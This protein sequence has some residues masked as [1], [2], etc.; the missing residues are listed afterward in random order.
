MMSSNFL[1]RFATRI[2]DAPLMIMPEKLAIITQALEGRIGPSV[3]SDL[4]YVSPEGANLEELPFMQPSASRFVGEGIEMDERGKAQKLP[5]QRTAS[6]QAIITVSGSLMNRGAYIG[7]KSGVLSYEGISAQLKA[8]ASDPKVKSIVLDLDSPGGE[9]VGAME[10]AALVRKI[11]KEKHVYS[12]VNGLAASAGYA[13]ASGARAIIST[14]SGVSGSIGVVVQHMDMSRAADRAGVN[15]SFVHAGKHKVDGHSFAP[16]SN[17]VRADLQAEVDKYYDLFVSA[18]AEGRGRRMSAKSVRA[19]EA[20]TFIGQAAKEAGLVD[21][22]GSFD[23]LLD[24]LA[25][26]S[27]R[28]NRR[29]KH[30]TLLHDDNELERASAEAKAAGLAEGKK[31]GNEEGYARGIAEGRELGVAE[32]HEAGLAAGATAERARISA[33][34]TSEVAVGREASAN[35]LAFNSNMSVE[36]ATG[37]LASVPATT[38]IAARSASTVST[39]TV[40]TGEKTATMQTIDRQAIYNSVMGR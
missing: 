35:H 25:G 24:D 22:I 37:F 12:V 16:L 4:G 38:G 19:T 21:I 2:F 20:R 34:L 36:E 5:Y 15:V 32:G 11:N 14:E 31:A 17:D 8:A 7:A 1:A 6:G 29:S 26:S 33:I 27:A 9:A 39:H 23:L 10:T 13:L 40:D 18:V 3:L 28:S 30:M